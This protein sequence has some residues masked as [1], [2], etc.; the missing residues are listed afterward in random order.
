MKRNLFLLLLIFCQITQINGQN[1]IPNPEMR[2]IINDTNI[3]DT[4]VVVPDWF[5]SDGSKIKP[6]LTNELKRGTIGVLLFISKFPN[7]RAFLQTMLTETLEKDQEY[8][9]E[10][11]LRIAGSG[12]IDEIAKEVIFGMAFAPKAYLSKDRSIPIDI[13]PFFTLTYFNEYND[14]RKKRIRQT[15]AKE[16]GGVYDT[17]KELW[18]NNDIFIKTLYKAKGNED[19][20]IIGNFSKDDKCMQLLARKIRLYPDRTFGLAATLKEIAVMPKQKT[21]GR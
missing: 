1:L 2:Y 10:V 4:T 18:E 17:P 12:D 21:R 13:Q 14:L 11:K 3:Y 16:Y 7:Q 9:I 8:E 20:L 19:F 5:L 6:G 15:W